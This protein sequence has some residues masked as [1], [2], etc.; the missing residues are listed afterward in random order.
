MR[1]FRSHDGRGRQRR[2]CKQPM[3]SEINLD[4][5]GGPR[6]SRPMMAQLISS[7]EAGELAPESR[8]PTTSELAEQY[9]ISYVSAA[10]A[11]EILAQQGYISRQPGRGT[12]VSHR[13]TRLDVQVVHFVIIGMS[14]LGVQSG[15]MLQAMAAQLHHT[16]MQVTCVDVPPQRDADAV[17][18]RLLQAPNQAFVI[19]GSQSVQRL[20]RIIQARAP[21][22]AIGTLISEVVGAGIIT[23]DIEST[24]YR[25]ARRLQDTGHDAI[26][27]AYQTLLRAPGV[28]LLQRGYRNALGGQLAH[29]PDF[30]TMPID[31]AYTN[32][33]LVDHIAATRDQYKRPAVIS[34]NPADADMVLAG[35]EAKGVSVPRDLS[36]VNIGDNQVSGNQYAAWVPPAATC[37]REAGQMLLEMINGESPR[38]IVL[39]N[40]Y[41]PGFSATD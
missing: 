2:S 6:V 11:L 12:F 4:R 39:A 30:D 33:A 29:L 28:E 40:Q 34:V 1:P 17:L 7:I 19:L 23:F 9:G 3:M 14:P 25:A 13:S 21:L 38:Q 5:L 18:Q 20:K 22:V 10:K 41:V 15:Q 32:Q 36:I 16:E 8:L 24:A 26:F 27:L 37:G 31:Q 35:L